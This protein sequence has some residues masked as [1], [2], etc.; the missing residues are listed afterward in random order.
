MW[1]HCD[2]NKGE[3]YIKGWDRVYWKVDV[4]LMLINNNELPTVITDNINDE[5]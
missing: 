1:M 4:Q 3:V 5:L 2:Y